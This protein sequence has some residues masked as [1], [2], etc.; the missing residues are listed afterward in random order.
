MI[1]VK[2]EVHSVYTECTECELEIDGTGTYI[3]ENNTM[4]ID[5]DSCGNEMIVYG[6]YDEEDLAE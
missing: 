3:A 2:E 4:Y 6:W 5:C 1:D